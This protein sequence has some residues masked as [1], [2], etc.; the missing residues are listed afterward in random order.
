MC[1]SS[2]C[3]IGGGGGKFAHETLLCDAVVSFTPPVTGH[4]SVSCIC[5]TAPYFTTPTRR[6]LHVA[7]PLPLFPVCLALNHCT[8]RLRAFL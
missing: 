3:F 6:P 8:L 5:N 7:R 1:E 4:S 2:V